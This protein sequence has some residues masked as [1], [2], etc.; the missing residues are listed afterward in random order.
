MKFLKYFSNK[1]EESIFVIWGAFVGA[2]FGLAPIT[3]LDTTK[4]VYLVLG[5]LVLASII[6]YVLHIINDKA[7]RRKIKEN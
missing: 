2:L 7:F 6:G 4:V 3:H 5:S 1:I